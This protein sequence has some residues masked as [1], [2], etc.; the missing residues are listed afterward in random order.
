M[1]LSSNVTHNFEDM[2]STMDSKLWSAPNVLKVVNGKHINHIMGRSIFI[3]KK[4]H[5]VLALVEKPL[6]FPL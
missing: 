1:N 4:G 5:N 2:I 3:N 6:G